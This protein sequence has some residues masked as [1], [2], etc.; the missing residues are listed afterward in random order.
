MSQRSRFASEVRTNA[1]LRVPTSARTSLISH[2][3]VTFAPLFAVP[4]SQALEYFGGTNPP[5]CWT[6][7]GI[8]VMDI[9]PDLQYKPDPS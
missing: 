7:V 9:R 8:S 6:Y 5:I 4:S 2:S 1:P 3:L